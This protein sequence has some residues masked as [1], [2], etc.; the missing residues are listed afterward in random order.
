[1]RLILVV[2]LLA[3][4]ASAVPQYEPIFTDYHNQIGILEAA[5]IK[6]AEEAMDF[7][8]SRIA[9]G[10][11]SGLGQFPFFGG[12]L[13]TLMHGPTSVCG[14]SVLSNTRAVTAAHCWRHHESRGRILTIVLGSTRLFSGGTR[15]STNRVVIH[16]SYHDSI[17]AND[18]AMIT[19][20]HVAFSNIINRINLPAGA[21]TYVGWNAV[22][23]GFG[24]TGDG[25]AGNIN[26]NQV[27]RHVTLQVISNDECRRTFGNVMAS[28]LCTSGAG[29]RSTCGGDS[30]GP[31][32]V[33]G[34]ALIG[35]TSFGSNLG[36]QRGFPA[37]YAR[38]TSFVAWIRARM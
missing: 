7:D 19:F 36:C 38:V 12:L 24:R 30:G 35:I 27:L 15:V 8:G 1:M 17:L 10:A 28:T 9:G 26:N 25:A 14:S 18:V 21:A 16:D 33:S 31:L 20:N 4:A 2:L 6:A 5:R 34:P 29:G 3:V 13:I 23:V 32:W 11:V 22:A 37:A